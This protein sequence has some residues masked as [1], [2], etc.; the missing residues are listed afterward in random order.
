[1]SQTEKCLKYLEHLQ[2]ILCPNIAIMNHFGRTLPQGFDER[3]Q[4]QV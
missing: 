1:M 4:P 3:E 2:G